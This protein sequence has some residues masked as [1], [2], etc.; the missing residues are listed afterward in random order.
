MNLLEESGFQWHF[1]VAYVV[2]FFMWAYD[3]VAA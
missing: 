1:F 2:A 3:G